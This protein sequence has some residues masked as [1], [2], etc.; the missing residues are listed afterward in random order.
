MDK[1]LDVLVLARTEEM[2]REY[3]AALGAIERL[4]RD[5]KRTRSNRPLGELDPDSHHDLIVVEIGQAL[6]EAIADIEDF[7]MHRDPN[8]VIFA[9]YPSA[10]VGTVTRLMRAGVRDAF[11][12]PLDHQELTIAVTHLLSQRRAIEA[13]VLERH[14]AVSAFLN[15]RGGAG[16]TYLAVN[17]AYLLAAEKKRRT[18]LVDLDVQF[19]TAA[20]QLNL[21]ADTGIMVALRDPDRI[22]AVFLNALAVHHPSG[23]AVIGAPT[24][25]GAIDALDPNAIDRLVRTLCDEYDHVVLNLPNFLNDGVYQALRMSHPVY[26]VLQSTVPMLR[27]LRMLLR[28]LPS[29]HVLHDQIEVI[30]NRANADHDAVDVEAI[31]RVVGALP[32]HLIRTDHALAA[33]S[34]NEGAAAAALDGRARSIKDLRELIKGYGTVAEPVPAVEQPARR[35]WFG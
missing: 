25:I 23:L 16:A 30:Y 2:A 13:R 26:L 7:L 15:V 35:S 18:V 1:E 24:T 33:R 9:S 28:T 20:V 21:D 10:D 3:G 5:V 31:R 6:D 29:Q 14:G 27:N 17:A 11:R 19:G 4:R 12:Q 8:A 34:E 32:V 22:D